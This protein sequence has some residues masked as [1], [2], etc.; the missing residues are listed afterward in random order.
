MGINF[1]SKLRT[2]S[3]SDVINE[4]KS[5]LGRTASEVLADSNA[6]L[7][8]HSVVEVGF[9]DAFDTDGD[10]KP[11][12]DRVYSSDSKPSIL[13]TAGHGFYDNGGVEFRAFPDGWVTGVGSGKFF[14]VEIR[15]PD[16]SYKVVRTNGVVD[17]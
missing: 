8:S 7:V 9:V 14:Q 5:L 17:V 11:D 2:S 10:G 15:F 1:L 13:R 3:Q 6:K 4:A 12:V 16:G